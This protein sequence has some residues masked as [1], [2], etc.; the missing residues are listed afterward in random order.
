MIKRMMRIGQLKQIY[1]MDYDVTMS[2]RLPEQAAE[3]QDGG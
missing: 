3:T 2:R 1:G